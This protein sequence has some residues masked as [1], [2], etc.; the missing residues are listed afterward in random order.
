[1]SVER[2]GSSWLAV[3]DPMLHDDF[4]TASP[5]RARTFRTLLASLSSTRK[6]FVVDSTRLEP[7]PIV[8]SIFVEFVYV[9]NWEL[10]RQK[11]WQACAL[12]DDAISL[13]QKGQVPNMVHRGFA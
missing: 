2:D 3:V 8:C 7:I 5:T 11:P 1:M 4:C 9:V 13:A 12:H 10:L 6:P